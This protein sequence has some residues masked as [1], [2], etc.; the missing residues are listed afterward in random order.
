[1]NASSN[2]SVRGV[3][4]AAFALATLSS[5]PQGA[6]S[7]LLEPSFPRDI[8]DLAFVEGEDAVS[9]NMAAEPTQN[10]GC[11]GNRTLQLARGGKLPGDRPFYAEY[12][13]RVEKAGSYELWYGGTPPG[14][15]DE[16]GLS[17][18]SPVSI[19][20]DGGMPR[21]FHREDVNVV[22]QYAP[23]YYWVRTASFDLA[24]GSHVIRF[25]VAEKRRL[26]DRWFFYLDA[27]FLA[28]RDA[29]EVMARGTAASAAAPTRLLPREPSSR[30]IDRPFRSIEDYQAYLQSNPSSLS[31]YLELSAIYSLSGDYLASL[32]TLSRAATV[33]PG[34]PRVRLLV[35]K[36]RIW[37]GDVKEGLDA[38]RTYLQLKPDDLSGYAEAGKVASWTGRYAEAK[39][40]YISGLAAFPGELSL[41]VNLG[42]VQLWNSEPREA[43][44]SF[45]AAE[46]AALADSDASLRLASIYRT[47]GYPDKALA[48]YERAILAYPDL[49]AFYLGESEIYAER[50]DHVRAEAA[51]ARIAAVFAPS[52]KL[53]AFLAAF[54]ARRDL[55][56]ERI[57]TLEEQVAAR[58]EDLVLREDL[59]RVYFWNGFKEK[60]VLQLES[61]LAALFVAELDKS[62]AAEP[63]LA[64]AEAAASALRADATQRLV[65]LAKLATEADAH[66]KAAASARAASEEWEKR[67][68]AAEAAAAEAAAPTEPPA[69]DASAVSTPVVPTPK[70]KTRVSAPPDPA[71]GEALATT[72]VAAELA[73]VDAT[74]AMTAQEV[75]LAA[76]VERASL[77]RQAFAPVADR[78]QALE[79]D[80]RKIIEPLGWTWDSGGA[81]AEL[82][83][84][85]G[86]GEGIA[87]YGRA[88]V[89]AAAGNLKEAFAAISSEAAQAPALASRRRV[90]EYLVRLRA[91]YREARD[92]ASSAAASGELPAGSAMEAAARELVAVDSV[93]AAPELPAA[94]EASAAADSQAAFAAANAAL[95]ALRRSV[96]DSQADLALLAQSAAVLCDKRL[97][98]A[99]YAFEESCSSR[100][101]ELGAYYDG[102]GLAAAAAAQYR[103][104]LA[105]DPSNIPA[106]YNLAL[107]EDRAGDWRG[108]ARHLRAVYA[109]DPDYGNAAS[110]YNRIARERAKGFDLD[111]ALSA[112]SNRLDYKA[113]AKLRLP[114]TSDFSLVISAGADSIREIAEALPAFLA[115]KLGVEAPFSIGSAAGP[116]LVVRPQVSLIGTSADYASDGGATTPPGDFL[117]S[118]NIFTAGGL[119]LDF[120]A[121]PVSGSASYRWEPLADTLNPSLYPLYAHCGELSAGAYVSL[122]A[123]FRY[124]A[125]RVYGSLNYVPR[126]EN[127]FGTALLEAIPAFRLSDA[128]WSNLGIP[129][130]LVLE[131]SRTPRSTPYYAADQALTAKGGLLWQSVFSRGQG[132]AVSTSVQAMGGL[133]QTG[134]FS[135]DPERYPYL[136]LLGRLEWIGESSTYWL[137]FD[138][139]AA[140]PFSSGDVSYWSFSFLCGATT[141]QPRLIA[142]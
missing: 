8:E 120:H 116:N 75:A 107:A 28:S 38:Y 6:T 76:L 98:R 32:K 26:D 84:P 74:A 104:V 24:E 12:V 110:I 46:V 115:A 83:G 37:R 3:F 138:A 119:A 80:F 27:F 35:A 9:T 113:T 71:E 21:A 67:R 59:T 10:Y 117:E 93:A 30:A 50:G 97:V 79:S 56:A 58:P 17:L 13:V 137:S 29:L 20:V 47:N 63:E 95:P 102:L 82:A 96:A 141:R 108:A 142:P 101:A 135:S 90:A 64:T 53:S 66:A 131:S 103:R 86:R 87:A 78:E 42:L 31:A 16:F 118:L 48:F 100:R 39:T 15:A 73:L 60:A 51:E 89:L 4:L 62:D 72:R 55:K 52:P 132:E 68:A 122:P 114:L 121:G 133:Y 123:P 14:P 54:K 43:E 11:S 126:D 70:P 109:A 127:L 136:Q 99:W 34:D 44:R 128:P 125:P 139:A 105:L 45:S 112:D 65:A 57:R 61:I 92:L 7:S 81:A 18:S 106:T 1:M 94:A 2:A 134:T 77:L 140:G 36:N 5:W 40:F 23:A 25:E 33:A 111:S 41:L 130:D 49:L 129:L 124:L 88:R 22:E 85:A 91:D 19:V 69:S